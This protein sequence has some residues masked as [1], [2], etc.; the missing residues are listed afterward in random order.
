MK[1]TYTFLVIKKL[2]GCNVASNIKVSLFRILSP[3]KLQKLTLK[4][5]KRKLKRHYIELYD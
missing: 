3:K 4:T 1:T 5:F 2:V